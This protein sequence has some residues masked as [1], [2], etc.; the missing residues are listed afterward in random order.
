LAARELDDTEAI[1]QFRE[2]LDTAIQERLVADV[3]VACYLS[4]GVDSCAM[5]ALAQRH[6]DRPI[7]AFTIGFGNTA[8][9]E[10]TL[11]RKT[12]AFTGAAFEPLPVNQQQIAD[13]FPD[14]IWHAECSMFNGHGVAKFLLSRAVRDA[15]I[16]VV[17]TGEGS[18]EILAGYPFSRR[19][20][21][22]YNCE[23]A[24][25]AMVAQKRKKIKAQNRFS[26]WHF[27]GAGNG[28]KGL[29]AIED[30]LGFVPSWFILNSGIASKLQPLLRRELRD[31][32]HET[33]PLNVLVA[34]SDIEGTLAGCN[35]VN[36]G[37]YLWQ[38]SVLP[39]YNLVVL[40]DRMEMAHSVEGR[41]PFLDHKVAELAANLPVKFKIRGQQEKWVLREACRDLLL[42][43]V[44]GGQKHIFRSPSATQTDD[45]MA[46]FVADIVHS[47]ALDDQPFFD[48]TKVR[49][50]HQGLL[51]TK[52]QAR[53]RAEALLL[54]VV[55]T[56]L[57]HQRF[58]L[59]L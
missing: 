1:M 20:M 51:S 3:E 46:V 58:R 54:R 50:F 53:A 10:T 32:V 12:A 42:P 2:V 24:D 36:Q 35:P 40:G 41:M 21:A 43:E 31:F 45:P 30:R 14:A 39:N 19:D 17:L 26:P 22:L 57:L 34:K 6:H 29:D 11:A 55:S 56:A 47:Q 8:Y 27:Y 37:L 15:G 49:K 48:P 33:D 28:T 25:P 7:R 13:A 9:D 59:S 23:G 4:G 16:K 44:R 18:D 38:K 52:P 5:L